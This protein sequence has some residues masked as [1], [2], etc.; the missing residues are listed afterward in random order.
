M[1]DASKPY[2]EANGIENQFP[3]LSS[4]SLLFNIRARCTAHTKCHAE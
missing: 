1:Y 2:D 3:E 4:I